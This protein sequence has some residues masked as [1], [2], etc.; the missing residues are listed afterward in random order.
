M[1]VQMGIYDFSC[2]IALFMVDDA[3]FIFCDL[4]VSY[5]RM[6]PTKA[7]RLSVRVSTYMAKT[8]RGRIEYNKAK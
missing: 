1:A 2:F 5:G 7:L 3:L 6:D 8:D 4:F